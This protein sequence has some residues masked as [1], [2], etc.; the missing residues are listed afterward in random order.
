MIRKICVVAIFILFSSPAHGQEDHSK[1]MKASYSNAREVTRQC[2]E[3]HAK[4]GSDFMKTA[5]WLWKG[6]TPFL[7]GHENRSDLGKINLMNDY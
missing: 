3:C 5:H 6:E 7:K 2:L 4:E 1:L